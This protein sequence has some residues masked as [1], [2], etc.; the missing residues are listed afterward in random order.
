VKCQNGFMR[1][2][3]FVRV[4]QGSSDYLVLLVD[5]LSLFIDSF[6]VFIVDFYVTRCHPCRFYFLYLTKSNANMAAIR[7]LKV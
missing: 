6:C 4:L 2:G 7:N 5:V 1:A 3:E